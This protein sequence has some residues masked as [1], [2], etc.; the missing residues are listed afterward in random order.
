MGENCIDPK[1]MM[2]GMD[3]KCQKIMDD[4]AMDAC[5][6]CMGCEEAQ[7]IIE[8]RFGGMEKMFE[9]FKKMEEMEK[10]FCP[11]TGKEM[12]EEEKMEMKM[13]IMKNPTCGLK[14]G[15]PKKDVHPDFCYKMC[16]PV[17]DN[18]IDPK[19]MMNG[20]DEKCQKMMDD[21]AMDA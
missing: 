9:F 12:S 3:E 7:D 13:E 2:N 11:I 21:P 6:F 1:K 16:L 18:C 15:D 5:M 4:P 8:E 10:D 20:M 17:L 14:T 19:K